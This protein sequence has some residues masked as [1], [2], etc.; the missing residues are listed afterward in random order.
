[1]MRGNNNPHA[2]SEVLVCDFAV[3]SLGWLHV[4]PFVLGRQHGREFAVI[5]DGRQP[6]RLMNF[7]QQVYS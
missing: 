3:V 2:S 5:L 4:L 7:S 1:M 6:L